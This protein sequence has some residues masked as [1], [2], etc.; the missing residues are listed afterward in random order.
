MYEFLGGNCLSPRQ[1]DYMSQDEA[2][3]HLGKSAPGVI[4]SKQKYFVFMSFYN[5]FSSGL[6]RKIWQYM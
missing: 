6:P 3:K 4:K 5:R 1:N 2:K